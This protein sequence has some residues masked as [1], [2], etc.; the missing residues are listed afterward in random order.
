MMCSIAVVDV[1]SGGSSSRSNT[2]PDTLQQAPDDVY[3]GTNSSGEGTT[4]RALG[5]NPLTLGTNHGIGTHPRASLHHTHA[6]SAP[7]HEALPA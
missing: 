4:S 2:N 6:H 3:I 1:A 7:V 5:T